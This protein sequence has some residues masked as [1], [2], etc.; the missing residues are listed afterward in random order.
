[1]TSK[2]HLLNLVIT[3]IALGVAENSVQAVAKYEKDEK[4][5]K[6]IQ[7]F[8]I[9]KCAGTGMCAISKEKLEEV[10]KNFKK[11]KYSDTSVH[12]C[13]GFNKCAAVAKGSAQAGILEWVIKTSKDDC[14]KEGG[15]VFNNVS[16]RI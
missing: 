2:K 7:C 6:I 8:G 1:M 5:A 3:G 9:Q 16:S 4:D 10:R 12:S 14:V 11:L 13:K 15:F